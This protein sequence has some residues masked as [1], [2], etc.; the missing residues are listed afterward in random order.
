MICIVQRVLE[1]H[2]SVGHE[3][4]G[5][6]GSGLVVLAA[7]QRRD[8]EADITWTAGK[9]T[10][11]RIFPS[12]DGQKNFDRDV[13]EIG[14]GILLVSNFTV[15]A[16]T[17]KGRRPSLDNA[18]DPAAGRVM[19]D[20]LLAAVAATG[21][22]TATGRFGA[23]MAVHLVNDGPVTMIVESPIRATAQET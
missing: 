12:A 8:T 10:T 3:V 20:K 22:P 13:K 17:A 18:A 1:A 4:V 21:I 9:L 16:A 14:G 5:R 7:V 19:F 2:V 11:L 23:D 6:I 15:A